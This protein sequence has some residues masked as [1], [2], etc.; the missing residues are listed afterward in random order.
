[1]KSITLILFTL[2]GLN[3]FAQSD[4]VL[5]QYRL[6]IKDITTKGSANLVQEPLRELFRVT[7]TYQE[8]VGTFIFESYQDITEKDVNNV[9]TN[10][11]LTKFRREEV[12]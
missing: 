8:L 2:I 9:L 3:S 11:T 12:K 10:F 1:M 5:Y 6:T 4:T 7:P